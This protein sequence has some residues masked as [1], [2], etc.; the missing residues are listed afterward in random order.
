VEIAKDLLLICNT[1][2]AGS[3]F[4]K[5][6]YLAHRPFAAFASVLEIGCPTGEFMGTNEFI[7]Q[8]RA[9]LLQ[10]LTSNPT[11][12]P[13][14]VVLFLDIPSR[15]TNNYVVGGPVG[16]VSYAVHDG[17][18]GIKPFVT[19]IHMGDTNA[20]KAYIDKLE[21]FG[22]NYSRGE[23]LV[24][25]NT[26]GY[27][28]Q[29][30]YF[31]ESGTSPAPGV[32]HPLEI[33]RDAVVASGVPTNRCIYSG[34]TNALIALASNVAAYASWGVY[35]NSDPNYATNGTIVFNGDSRW[36]IM[37]TIESFNGQVQQGVPQGNHVKWFS[38]G[39]FGGTNYSNTPIGG[40]THVEEPWGGY[41]DAG[42]YF[43]H[44]SRGR[45]FAV[46]AWA[47]FREY[48]FLHFQAIGDPLVR[49]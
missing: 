2:S 36:Y 1:N 24:S 18:P 19:H 37:S 22:T 6:Y 7:N 23:V 26:G 40:I 4:V 34:P 17:F 3:V 42:P 33:A 5:N 15:M 39:A 38:S 29:N 47:G 27:S 41:N 28:N 31:D 20:C 14:Y 10:W 45:S 43:I 8:L 48:Y 25:A 13:Q 11:K 44:W 21:F 32:V 46:C 35:N 30:Y 9:P 12:P 16:S 49:R